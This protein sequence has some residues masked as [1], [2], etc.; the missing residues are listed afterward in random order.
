MAS[1]DSKMD[2]NDIAVEA[3][4]SG[5]MNNLLYALVLLAV[6]YW[7]RDSIPFLSSGPKKAKVG[8]GAGDAGKSKGEA[9]DP[10]DFVFKMKEGVSICDRR[11]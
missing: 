4:K 8:A 3:A 1:A 11:V 2:T 6:L 5:S 10:D 7:G 9:D